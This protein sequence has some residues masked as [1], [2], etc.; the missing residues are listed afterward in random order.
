MVKKETDI[1][2]LIQQCLM[3]RKDVKFDLF[4]QE[5]YRY[6]RILCRFKSPRIDGEGIIRVLH[7]RVKAAV[8]WATERTHQC[9]LNPNNIIDSSSNRNTIMDIF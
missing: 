9:M 5:A 6:D 8:H 7:G 4:I 3:Q 2:W 1:Q